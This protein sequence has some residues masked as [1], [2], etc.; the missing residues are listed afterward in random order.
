MSVTTTCRDIDELAPLAR[1]AIILFFQECHKAGIHI[2][3]TETYRSQARQNYLYEQGRTRK[4]SIVTWVRS[5]R[6]TN[7]MAWDIGAATVNG[8]TNIYNSTI[9]KKAGA[10]A[11]KLGITWGGTWKN[12]LDYPHFEITSGWK[13][14]KGYSIKGAVSIPTRSSQLV[15][16]VGAVTQLPKVETVIPKETIEEELDMTK[17]VPTIADCTTTALKTSL[18]TRLKEAHDRGLINDKKWVEAAESGNLNIVD[19]TLLLN[20][21]GAPSTNKDHSSNSL[22]KSFIQMLEDALADG[23][24]SSDTWIKKAKDGKL[25]VMDVIMLINTITERRSGR[26]EIPK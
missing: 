8:N 7:R 23:I 21:I 22:N 20:H 19:A 2:F 12:N 6:H 26:Q 3:V 24:I 16:V 18:I 9:I 25:Q 13:I 4:G 15:K 14:P 10:I 1:K 17:N 11:V 5:S